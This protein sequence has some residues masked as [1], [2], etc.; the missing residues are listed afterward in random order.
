MNALASSSHGWEPTSKGLVPEVWV[1][2]F[3]NRH[4]NNIIRLTS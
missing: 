2:C 1:F 4:C 3:V